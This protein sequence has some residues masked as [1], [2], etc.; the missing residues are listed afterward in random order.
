MLQPRNFNI[1]IDDTCVCKQRLS[2]VQ[3]KAILQ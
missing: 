1:T 3:G 2:H